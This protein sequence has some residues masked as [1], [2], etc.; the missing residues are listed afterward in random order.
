MPFDKPTIVIS[1]CLLNGKC[2]HKNVLCILNKLNDYVNIIPVCPIEA[3]NYNGNEQDLM[4]EFSDELHLVDVN[5]KQDYTIEISQFAK[6]F[7]ANH[8]DI[9]SYILKSGSNT[10]GIREITGYDKTGNQ[11]KKSMMGMFPRALSHEKESIFEDETTLINE[12][13]RDHYFNKLFCLSEF[14]K[15]KKDENYLSLQEFHNKNKLLLKMY[16]ENSF[17]ILDLLLNS[18]QD[19]IF[20]LYEEILKGVFD[21]IYQKN[22]FKQITQEIIKEFEDYI[23]LKEQKF[24]NNLLID[25]DNNVV[26]QIILE[27]IM[28]NNLLRFNMEKLFDQTIFERYP[29][30]IRVISE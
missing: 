5:N 22:D 24:L 28:K 29:R 14:E 27:Y 30:Q 4:F 10:C 19:N 3:I 18:Y 23:N 16:D 12:S 20:V 13:M 26:S 9:H 11:I 21:E 15:I 7:L 25:F 17:E 8:K 6:E 2:Q 1:K